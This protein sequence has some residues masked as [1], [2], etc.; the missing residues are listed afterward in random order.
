MNSGAIFRQEVGLTLNINRVVVGGNVGNNGYTSKLFPGSINSNPDYSSTAFTMT[1]LSAGTDDINAQ[2]GVTIATPDASFTPVAG[3][4][5]NQSVTYTQG[6]T[7]TSDYFIQTEVESFSVSE[8]TTSTKT[9]I[10]S[11][12]FSGSTSI[13][14]SLSSYNGGT[15]PSFVSIDSA[16]GILSIS[17][18]SVLSS[19]IYSF[20]V[21]STISGISGVFHKIINLTVN[22]CTSSNCQNCTVTDSTVCATCNSGYNL[23][24]GS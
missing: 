13:V 15:I 10:L 21:D 16:T 9:P 20:Y 6:S 4:Y 23:S 19:T 22:K 3:G 2:V 1:A 11:C 17:A 14:Y 7:S 12:S 5:A 8:L 18:P 24:S